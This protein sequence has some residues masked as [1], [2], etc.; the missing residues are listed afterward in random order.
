MNLC[1][2]NAA[3][4]GNSYVYATA[5]AN[6]VWHQHTD[7]AAGCSLAAGSVQTSTPNIQ[8]T[9]NTA[10][11]PPPPLAI[12]IGTGTTACSYPFYTLYED[13]RTQMIYD[14]AEILA[15]GG[16]PGEITAIALDV[17]SIG[18]PG[19]N[20]FSIDMQNYSGSTLSAFENTGWTNTFA[21]IYTVAG[22]GWQVFTLDTPF[23]WDGSSNL[24][25]NICFDNAAWSGNSVVNGSSPPQEKPFISTPMEPL[26]VHLQQALFRQPGQTSS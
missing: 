24:L 2:D 26:A 9:I 3:W 10:P 4:S 7:G 18:A 21:G 17:T 11:P 8:M 12:Q 23:D 22:T 16:L 6:K 13:A 19:M 25:I 5:S 14:A 20:G 1:W 15:A